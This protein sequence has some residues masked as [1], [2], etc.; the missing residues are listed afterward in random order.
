VKVGGKVR[1]MV[2]RADGELGVELYRVRGIF[3]SLSP[4]ISRGRALAGL[5]DAEDTGEAEQA[6]GPRTG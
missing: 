3:H 4:A 6:Q 5:G 2:Q 1:M